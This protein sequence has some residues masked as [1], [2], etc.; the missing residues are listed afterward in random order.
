M[1]GQRMLV[2]VTEVIVLPATI[3]SETWVLLFLFWQCCTGLA[4]FFDNVQRGETQHSAE[5]LLVQGSYASS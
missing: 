2:S 3:G 1:T 5:F 4:V